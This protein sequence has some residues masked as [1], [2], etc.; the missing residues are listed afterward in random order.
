M[1][2]RA[3][4]L[5]YVVDLSASGELSDEN[6]VVLAAPPEWSPEH[7]LLAALVDE[8]DAEV[9]PPVGER[10]SLRV[11]AQ[12]Q[13]L[14]AAVPSVLGRR[15]RSCGD[16]HSGVVTELPAHSW[17]RELG[18]RRDVERDLK[19]YRE[20]NPNGRPDPRVFPPR[21]VAMAK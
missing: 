1:A 5:R 2:V 14:R 4:E 12:R 20:L 11:E 15:D 21:F 19:T 6:G 3:K 9:E 7:L 13:K 18:V 10:R 17:R 16:Q 8:V